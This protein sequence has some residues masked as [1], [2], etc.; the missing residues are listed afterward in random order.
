[1]LTDYRYDC[2]ESQL[3][4]DGNPLITIYRQYDR[5]HALR[6]ERRKQG[7]C[8]EETLDDFHDEPGKSWYEQSPIVELVSRHRV[9]YTR[10]GVSREVVSTY[11]YDEWGNEV[12]SIGP[13]GIAERTTYYDPAGEPGCPPD[14][15]W[16]TPRKERTVTREPAEPDERVVP[17]TVTYIYGLMSSIDPTA[18]QFLH[19]TEQRQSTADGDFATITFDYEDNLQSPLLH[20]RLRGKTETVNGLTTMTQFAYDVVGNELI[21]DESAHTDFDDTATHATV[22]RS[23]FSGLELRRENADEQVTYQHDAMGR[24]TR[25]T[26]LP[27]NGDQVYEAWV[28]HSYAFPAQAGGTVSHATRNAS[29]VV[30]TQHFDGTGLLVRETKLSPEMDGQTHHDVRLVTYDE[31][32]RAVREIQRDVV[33]GEV[34]ANTLNFFFDDWG[35]R[36]RVVRSDGVTEHVDFNPVSLM[37]TSWVSAGSV[38]SGEQVRLSNRF[39]EIEREERF[40]IDGT[41]VSRASMTYDGMGR[42]TSVTE[43]GTGT[44]RYAYD[45]AD[46]LVSETLPDDTVVTYDYVPHSL[47]DALTAVHVDDISVGQREFDGLLRVVSQ[48]VGAQRSTWAFD[49]DRSHPREERTP[50]GDVLGYEVNPSLT[51]RMKRRTAGPLEMSYEYEPQSGLLLRASSQGPGQTPIDYA[52]ER[53]SVG[54]LLKETWTDAESS[55]S[56]E[57]VWT[58]MGR[59]D[60]YTDATG[61]VHRYL[62]DKDTSRLK[63]VQCGEVSVAFAYDSLGRLSEQR[64]TQA[65]EDRLTVTLSY[66][67]IGRE[68]HREFVAPSHPVFSISQEYDGFDRLIART[69]SSGGNKELE[70]NFSYDERSRLNLYYATGANAPADPHDPAQ[71]IQVQQWEYDK[72]DNITRISTWHQGP[73]KPPGIAT[74]HY[75][76]D[77]DPTQLTSL[78]RSDY[79]A[80]S[81]TQTFRY[82]DAGRMIEAEDGYHVVYD[83]FDHVVSISRDNV[84]RAAYRYNGMD[85]QSHVAVPSQPMRKRIFREHKLVTEIRGTLSRTYLAGGLGDLDETGALRVYATDQKSTVLQS[86]DAQGQRHDALYSPS[87]YRAQAAWHDGVPGQDGEIADPATQ[88]LWLGNS[89]MYSPVLAR[90]LVPDSYSPFDGG[91][92][93]RYARMDPVNSI[94]PSGHIPKWLAIGIAVVMATVAI[95]VAVFVPGGFSAVAIA[96]KVTAKAVA[97]KLG[98][99]SATSAKAMAIYSNVKVTASVFATIKFGLSVAGALSTMTS[100]IARTLDPESQLAVMLGHIGSA[101]TVAAFFASIP[102]FKAVNKGFTDKVAEAQKGGKA[103][104]KLQAIAK[105]DQ[106]KAARAGKKTNTTRNPGSPRSA[107]RPQTPSSTARDAGPSGSPD[108]QSLTQAEGQATAGDYALLATEQAVNVGANVNNY[109]AP[110]PIMPTGGG[111]PQPRPAPLMMV[112]EDIRLMNKGYLNY[113]NPYGTLPIQFST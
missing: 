51:T 24:V 42:Q 107:G 74:Y 110:Q 63:E 6:I 23:V 103:N 70:E 88:W 87:G 72:L 76:N 21:I 92:I 113:S 28:E 89:R 48:T 60:R 52:C 75:D 84:E 20:G 41:L 26:A 82:D 11:R 108:T 86:F 36:N 14:P 106:R 16:L 25:E 29:G 37:E 46:R 111:L 31:F 98:I 49:G 61:K 5:F 80:A 109:L 10:A 105:R 50:T 64:M 1:M 62:Y 39:D 68:I 65:G 85:E 13:D 7:D 93:N 55:H 44:T 95:A 15:I 22:H 38:V 59:P 57:H 100:T 32:G 99:V 66:D 43:L 3:D 27:V 12:E 17:T 67:D 101:L 4:A 9:R 94:D 34:I 53:D 102:G 90:F 35:Q 83:A 112:A 30:I 58:L 96:A 71:H 40:L 79:G 45:F 73:D 8:E 81:G 104:A 77:A 69:R 19:C 47:T 91:G 54:N 78:E 2:T 33:D 18:P 56:A 97:G